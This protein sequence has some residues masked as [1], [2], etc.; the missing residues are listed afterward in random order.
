MEQ[1]KERKNR[2]YTASAIKLCNPAE[3]KALLVRRK[4]L[5]EERKEAESALMNVPEFKTLQAANETYRENYDQLK[6]LIDQMGSYQDVEA[7]VY[8]L[9]YTRA[10]QNYVV[11]RVRSTLPPEIV[12]QVI[13]VSESVDRAKLNALVKNDRS[14][15][16][17]AEECMVTEKVV[18]VYEIKA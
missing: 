7:G 8:G 4:Q 12:K 18:V 13:V 5:E 9:T 15:R 1:T 6:L 3:V 17:K 2:D 14:L 11:E 10:T 16:D